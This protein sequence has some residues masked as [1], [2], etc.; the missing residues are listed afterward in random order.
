MSLETASIDL[1]GQ[2][3]FVTGGGRG[4]GR[5]IAVALAEQG[6]A[7]TVIARSPTELEETEAMIRSVGGEGESHVAD[8]LDTV[9]LEQAFAAT[10]EVDLLV[11]NAG[12]TGPVG[13]L[14]ET[15]ASDWWR[16]LE[17]NLLGVM[18]CCRRVLPGMIARGSGRIINIGSNA[19]FLSLSPDLPQ[20]S[21]YSVSKAA[22]IRFGET[23]ASDVS[24]AGVSVFTLS[25]GLVH[26]RMTQPLHEKGIFPDEAWTPIDQAA[27]FCLQLASGRADVLSGRYLHAREDDL[28]ALLAEAESICSEDRKVLRLRS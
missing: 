20:A 3:A 4:I 24:G 17:V 23:L 6:A 14:Q 11:N 13:P 19:A 5:A 2:R 18:R 8:I 28:D 12:I 26:T 9:A 27:A 25:P 16:T 21:A 10:G 7:V 1:T 22:L 15:E